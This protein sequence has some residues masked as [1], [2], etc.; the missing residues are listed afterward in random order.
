L[1]KGREF[2]DTDGPTSPLVVIVSQATARTFWGAADPIDRTS[3]RPAQNSTLFTVV[4]VVGD[5][6]ST[7]LNRESPALYFPVPWRT[8]PVMDVVVRTNG[9]P[10]L[11]MPVIRQRVHELDSDLALANVRTMDEWLSA[12]AA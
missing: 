10:A 1:V 5:V 3:H 7:T 2:L 9:A 11:L 4:G 12:S 6:R 8:A